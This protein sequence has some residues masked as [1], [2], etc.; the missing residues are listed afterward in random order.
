MKRRTTVLIAAGI[1]WQ[2][3]G[4]ASSPDYLS[5]AR[6]QADTASEQPSPFEQPIL[7]LEGWRLAA[8]SQEP[9]FRDSI[10]NVEPRFYYHYLNDGTVH[11]AFAGGG[12]MILTSGWWRDIFQVGIGG[13][14]TQP[15]ATGRDPGGTGLLRNNG[16]GFEVLG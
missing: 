11:E 13:Y 12:A 6:E 4:L 3:V 7:Q 1:F 8:R 15:L 2:N 14:T 9:F 10:Y 16:D 5:S